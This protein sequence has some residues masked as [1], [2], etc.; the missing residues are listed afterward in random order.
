MDGQERNYAQKLMLS[1][2]GRPMPVRKPGF[3]Y[4]DAGYAHIM[5]NAK[6][7]IYVKDD[8]DTSITFG[9]LD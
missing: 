2:K 8:Y 7:T 3:L 5:A 9:R 4:G 6:N 1:S